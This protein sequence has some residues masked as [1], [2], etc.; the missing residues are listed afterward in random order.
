MSRLAPRIPIDLDRRRYLLLDMNAMVEF[1]EATGKS[2]LDPWE[3]D[4]K[5]DLIQ[6][7]D[8]NGELLWLLDESG[9]P[10]LSKG[11][12]IPIYQPKNLTT[13]DIRALLWACL[14]DD[15]PDLTIKEAGKLIH[16]GN[17]AEV[18]RK[19]SEVQRRA[20][21]EKQEDEETDP[22]MNDRSQ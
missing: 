4:E 5:G 10:I 18:N 15:D 8:E 22:L 12:R 21:P 17:L 20:F 7:R 3:R 2:L 1:E 11:K 13:K 14:L 19:I 6:L 9:E 16:P